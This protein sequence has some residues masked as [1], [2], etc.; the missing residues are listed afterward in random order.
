MLNVRIS[1]IE[2]KNNRTSKRTTRQRERWSDKARFLVFFVVFLNVFSK[3]FKMKAFFSPKWFQ[4]LPQNNEEFSA[5]LRS[6]LNNNNAL[7][8]L[9]VVVIIIM[10][11][12][13][14]LK[15]YHRHHR[16]GETTKK[17]FAFY[18]L[19]F[20]ALS[21]WTRWQI[22]NRFMMKMTMNE[23]DSEAQNNNKIVLSHERCDEFDLDED[24]SST[25][26]STKCTCER[27]YGGAKCRDAMCTRQ[28]AP[29]GVCQYGYCLCEN[30][31]KGETCDVPVCEEEDGVKCNAEH[32]KCTNP[33]FCLCDEGWYGQTCEMRCERGEFRFL[34]QKCV[35]E[36]EKWVGEA[37][38]WA[39]CEQECSF[40]GECVKPDVCECKFGFSGKM[41]E[42]DDLSLFESKDRYSLMNAG[43]TVAALTLSKD[44]VE[45]EKGW[46]NVQKWTSHVKDEKGDQPLIKRSFI[47][48]LQLPE[49]DELGMDRNTNGEMMFNTCAIVGSSGSMQRTKPGEVLDEH[50]DQ[51][52][53]IDLA[54]TGAKYKDVAG[55]RTTFR[56]L[57][58]DSAETLIERKDL[59]D[60][61][62][63]RL[64]KFK[65]TKLL[66]WRAES[67]ELFPLLKT[68]FP[69]DDWDIMSPDIIAPFIEN[70]NDVKKELLSSSHS[71]T[72][73]EHHL[74]RHQAPPSA[75]LTLALAKRTCKYIQ[76]WGFDFTSYS[77]R[78]QTGE[79]FSYFS[80][81]AFE[82]NA[83][84]NGKRDFE[85]ALLRNVALDAE[86]ASVAWCD[87]GNA[88][89]CIAKA[90]TFQREDEGFGDGD[91]DP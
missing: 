84:E 40:H 49:V 2:I 9:K 12:G 21:L 53:R 46:R 86:D 29:H 22:S 35:C 55:L 66:L 15:K 64:R 80:S 67:Y 88:E 59:V 39:T 61:K 58:R 69:E 18:F 62:N 79:S 56:V 32:G 82:P 5:G 50:I 8:A 70:Y 41:C 68:K 45:D 13:D 43:G 24:F 42:R 19:W 54:P 4:N 10:G 34:E 60:P 51:I 72:A 75:L 74:Q 27:G 65:D 89:K 57:D 83:Y 52:F 23:D 90:K 36:S 47:S 71:S 77:Y 31:W 44:V 91:G 26:S 48:K 1:S 87:V 38:E 14:D 30:G 6:F 78:A 25:S 85:Y 3:R 11:G 17:R 7:A 33:N 63:P 20:L 81:P 76:V 28:C 16:G 73:D 37:C